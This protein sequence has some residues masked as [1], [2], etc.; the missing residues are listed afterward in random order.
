[1]LL[2]GATKQNQTRPAQT[3]RGRKGRD[4]IRNTMR[5]AR[6]TN[7]GRKEGVR[8]R[9]WCAPKPK[10][11]LSIRIGCPRRGHVAMRVRLG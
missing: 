6:I 2:L 8:L 4:D 11:P 5:Y 10:P 9:N 1:M 3:G 7:R